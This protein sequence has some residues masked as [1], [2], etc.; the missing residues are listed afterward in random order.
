[1][2]S[3]RKIFSVLFLTVILGGATFWLVERT[4][5]EIRSY[6]FQSRPCQ[7]PIAYAMGSIDPRFGISP[8]Q[9]QA[10]IAEA[11]QFWERAIGYPVFQSDPA[12]NF[13]IQLVYD[14]RQLASDEAAALE[15]GL[16]RL[17][18][19]QAALEKQRGRLS[20]AYDQK[21]AAF[22]KQM[23]EYEKAIE[24]YNQKVI[25]WNERGGATPE[26]Y[27]ELKKEEKALKKTA[28]SLTKKEEELNALAK[29]ANT[30]ID[31]EQNMV[32]EYN[33]AV[34][35]YRSQ[36]GGA[37]EFEKGVFDPAGITIYQFRERADLRMTLIHELGH[38]LGLGH[39]E[40]P[41]SIM[42]YLM[43]EQD[44]KQPTLTAED[45]QEMQRVCQFN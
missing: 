13:K 21:L 17:N 25:T 36:Y 19:Q 20:Q 9:F 26:V 12:A 23:S 11:V 10:D 27:A 43:G 18:S 33:E 37:Q 16:E 7:K 5:P 22:K 4:R 29:Q 40:N 6:F 14:E 2:Q 35:T 3:L 38:S 41:Q 1:M 30:I 45:R 42:Y 44:L 28:E 39:I 32:A 8:E 15:S 24:E 34:T 31:K